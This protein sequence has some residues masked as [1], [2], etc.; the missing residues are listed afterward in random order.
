MRFELRRSV[1]WVL[2]YQRAC[3]IME[4]DV[5]EL[6]C[7]SPWQDH[8]HYIHIFILFYF[9]SQIANKANTECINNQQKAHS[10]RG[11]A[12][13]LGREVIFRF[14]PI[15]VCMLPCTLATRVA[16]SRLEA[17]GEHTSSPTSFTLETQSRCHN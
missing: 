1:P 10:H 11:E 16:S 6:R 14:E 5:T 17:S 13:P 12:S 7:I 2:G 3:D 9:L 8:K 4:V 15:H